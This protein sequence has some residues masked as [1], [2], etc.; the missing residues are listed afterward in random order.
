[1]NCLKKNDC[2]IHGH[3]DYHLCFLLSFIVLELTFRSLIHL[4]LIFVYDMNYQI[5]DSNSE[6]DSPLFCS[7]MLPKIHRIPYYNDNNSA[8]L[9]LCA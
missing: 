9:A 8:L 7:E 4:E 6:F 5:L 1:M 2:I 3:T